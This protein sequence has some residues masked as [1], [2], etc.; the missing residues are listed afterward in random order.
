MAC[1][2]KLATVAMY[3][4]FV[5]THAKAMNLVKHAKRTIKHV[6]AEHNVHC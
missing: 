3:N 6:H 2:G 1:R 5:W 4:Y